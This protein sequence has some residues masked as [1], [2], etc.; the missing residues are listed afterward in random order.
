[1]GRPASAENEAAATEA[2]N[3]HLP[4]FEAQ[5]AGKDYVL[6]ADFTVADIVTR[7]TFNYAEL[8]EVDLSA[9]V[10][11]GLDEALRGTPG[12]RQG[13]TGLIMDALKITGLRKTY[14]GGV[15]ALKAPASRSARVI[16]SR[17]SAPTARA[18]R[19]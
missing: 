12:L 19:R 15:E 16:S 2:L 14:E 1:M 8:A 9:T 11:H 13:E 6:G 3:R 7:S 4:I 18:R 5:L 17:C 10:H